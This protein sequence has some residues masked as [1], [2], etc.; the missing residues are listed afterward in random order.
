MRSDYTPQE[1][2]AIAEA[3]DSCWAILNIH[4]AADDYCW[5]AE[6]LDHTVG[7]EITIG[8]VWAASGYRE[9]SPADTIKCGKWVEDSE[10]E[11]LCPEFCDKH[12]IEVNA[13]DDQLF[14]AEVLERAA[15]FEAKKA[16]AELAD[17][18]E[19]EIGHA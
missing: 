15:D 9:P 13:W 8:E 6:Y 2:A 7:E 12:A 18:G 1:Q 3:I 16:A 14:C 17:E 5:E 4:A 19:L 10:G 11:V